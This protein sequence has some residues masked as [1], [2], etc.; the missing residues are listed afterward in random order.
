MTVVINGTTGIDTIQDNTVSS[1]K[2]QDSSVTSAKVTDGAI[3]T[4][5]MSS[6]AVTS[7]KSGR[8]NL[9]I[10][11]GFDVWQ[12]GTS[13]S[14]NGAYA[15]DRWLR[16]LNYGAT[17]TQQSFTNGQ[18]DVPGS[19]KYYCRTAAG[20]TANPTG[21]DILRYYVEGL[22]STGSQQQVTLSFWAKANQSITVQ[23]RALDCFTW[24][25]DLATV[26]TNDFS[27]TTGW[28]K[29]THTFTTTNHTGKTY[30]D[31]ARF[32]LQWFWQNEQ[33]DGSDYFDIANVQL[34]L[35]D[36]ATDFEYRSYG[37]E[38]ALCQRY[39][40][41]NGGTHYR[42]FLTIG[43]SSSAGWTPFLVEKRTIPTV[44]ATFSGSVSHPTDQIRTNG[45]YCYASGNNNV[46]H[47]GFTA[48]A[49]L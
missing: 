5:D 20:A 43:T 1:T 48:D 17:V 22:H 49:E 42:L 6:A 37:E 24:A 36:T 27:I 11:G 31:S 16:S 46:W 30:A 34:E 26:G 15:A 23:V 47:T 8:K 14:S 45:F 28:Q 9:I 3:T 44:T 33:F 35:G 21:S 38:L 10:N 25:S 19:P 29:F 18:T 2:L 32:L 12:R 41:A 40:E 4:T 7:L 13:I 39:Y